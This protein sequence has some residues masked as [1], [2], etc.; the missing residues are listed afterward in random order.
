MRYKKFLMVLA[1]LILSGL[2]AIQINA[3]P[4][5]QGKG[6]GPKPPAPVPQTGQT[7]SYYPG[8]DG[9]LQR[10]VPCP[11]PRFTDNEDGTVTDNCTGLVWLQNANCLATSYPEFDNDGTAGDGR[12][13]WQHALD[14]VAG[15]NNGTYGECGASYTDW[16]LPNI[17][18]LLS[19]VDLGFYDP[20]IA[21]TSPFTNVQS[22][23]YW[24][25]SSVLTLPP[26]YERW[27]VLF[28][29]GS[30]HGYDEAFP[31][32]EWPVRGGN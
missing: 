21:H 29:N 4:K 12:V 30:A 31:A 3:E 8:D 18:E 24:S 20:A 14:F 10:G 19:L 6:K 9:D 7:E 23:Y 2:L 22:F 17:K 25:S 26:G 1:V 13:T 11:E 28:L 32:L 16:R 5:G 27:F 15:I